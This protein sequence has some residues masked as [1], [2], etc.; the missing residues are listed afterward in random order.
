VEAVDLGGASARVHLPPTDIQPVGKFR[1]EGRVVDAVGGHRVGV[2]PLGVQCRPAAI[3]PEGGVLHQHVGV[4]LRVALPAGAMVERRRGDPLAAEAVGAVVTA[5]HADCLL[6]QP[7]QHHADRGM[8]RLGHF[9]SNF[10]GAAGG[11]QTD[12]LGVRQRQV[13]RC[14]PGVHPP[15]GMPPRFRVRLAVQFRRVP[16]Q[17]RPADPLHRRHV[18]LPAGRKD[19]LELAARPLAGAQLGNLDPAGRGQLPQR[20]LERGGG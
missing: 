10:R 2:Q 13:K 9:R 8:P 3:R 18:D 1:S 7:R 17:N 5:A 19:R 6:L 12:A 11:Q 16:L 14:H 20:R 15:A 4:P